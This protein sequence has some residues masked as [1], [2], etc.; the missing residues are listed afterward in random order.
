MFAVWRLT[1]STLLIL[2]FFPSHGLAAMQAPGDKTV[3]R[4]AVVTFEVKDGVIPN[5]DPADFEIQA[6]KSKFAPSRIYSSGELPTVLAIVLPESLDPSFERHLP[7]LRE[8][9]LVQPK[10]TYVGIAYLSEEGNR[11]PINFLPDLSEIAGSLRAPAGTM[12]AGPKSS[13]SSLAVMLERMAGLPSARVQILFF[14]NRHDSTY[15]TA[16]LRIM[17][18]VEKSYSIGATVW[19]V[20][21]L[22]KY[23]K[24]KGLAP[25]AQVSVLGSNSRRILSQAESRT[26]RDASRDSLSFRLLKEL[27]EKTGGKVLDRM[28]KDLRPVL[29]E[30]QELLAHQVVLEYSSSEPAKKI[31]LKKKIRGVKI[32][33]PKQ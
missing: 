22:V 1:F 11:D 2:G 15:R 9:I 33:I 18:A 32:L 25:G 3:T 29:A 20:Q 27:A 7:A 16:N 21:S 23:E 17:Q 19:V 8:F 12:E 13:F 24:R 5:L 14:A 28:P 4:R 30:L 31:K 6:G 26:L 10:N